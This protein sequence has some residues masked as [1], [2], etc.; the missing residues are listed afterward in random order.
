[1]YRF[2]TKQKADKPEEVIDT[3]VQSSS[4]TSKF[5]LTNP[6][7]LSY[8]ISSASSRIPLDSKDE[9]TN[10]SKGVKRKIIDLP[11]WKSR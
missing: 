7:K 6:Q 1:M 2:L 11:N 9:I 5:E 3:P 10:Y 8:Q 4:R